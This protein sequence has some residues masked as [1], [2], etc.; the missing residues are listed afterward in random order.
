[1]QIRSSRSS[2]GRGSRSS[3]E[4]EQGVERLQNLQ[5]SAPNGGRAGV[6]DVAWPIDSEVGV[7]IGTESARWFMAH[8]S[9]GSA[10]ALAQYT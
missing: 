10:D 1:M 2:V 3:G 4:G 7:K 9:R 5:R 6:W 8:Y